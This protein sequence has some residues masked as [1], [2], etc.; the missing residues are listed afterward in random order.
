MT[1]NG[2]GQGPDFGTQE[3]MS[4]A[5]SYLEDPSDVECPRCGRD[6]IE[7][8]GYLDAGSIGSGQLLPTAPDD[9]YTVVLFCHGCRNAAALELSREAA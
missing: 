9:E 1:K 5:L 8:V 7:V 6:L 4:L 2:P 3:G